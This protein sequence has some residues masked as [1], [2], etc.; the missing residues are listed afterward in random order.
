MQSFCLVPAKNIK[1]SEIESA[2]SQVTL[3]LFLSRTLR[4]YLE[5]RILYVQNFE[6]YTLLTL[7][8]VIL[9][10]QDEIFNH[11]DYSKT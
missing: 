9:P 6:E 7:R 3:F 5:N 11:T 4:Y 1:I 2:N 10:N 8:S